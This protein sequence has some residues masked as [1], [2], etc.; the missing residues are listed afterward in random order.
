MVLTLEQD[1]AGVR[2][3]DPRQETRKRR[4]S[5]AGLADEP[6]IVA[7]E[8]VEAHAAHRLNI[9]IAEEALAGLDLVGFG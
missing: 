1:V 7:G 6:E 2:R 4:L 3:L 8:H 9:L 5:A